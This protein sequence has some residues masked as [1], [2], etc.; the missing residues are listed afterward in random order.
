MLGL[1]RIS[2]FSFTAPSADRGRSGRI[3]TTRFRDR[4]RWISENSKANRI[5]T[6]KCP[7]ESGEI[8]SVEVEKNSE[9]NSE[10]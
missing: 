10:E 6:M 7:A 9:E 1:G 2:V 5:E 4:R 8:C 3:A